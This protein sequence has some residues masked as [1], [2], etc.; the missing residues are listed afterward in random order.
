[1]EAQIGRYKAIIG[2]GLKSRKLEAQTSETQI[3]VKALN[4]MTDLGRPD[5]QRVI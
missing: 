3:A 4:R 2:S 5:Y 1:M